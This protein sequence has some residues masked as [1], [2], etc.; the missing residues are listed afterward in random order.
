MRSAGQGKTSPPDY[1]TESELIG[2]MEKHG[3]GTDAS[4]S[5]H[6][7]KVCSA[8]TPREQHPE[9]PP[10]ASTLPMAC[11]SVPTGPLYSVGQ[12]VLAEYFLCGMPLWQVCERY[13]SVQTGRRLVPT[14]LGVTLVRGYQLIDP[15]LC[16]PLVG[17]AHSGLHA[18]SVTTHV[19]HS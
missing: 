4:I 17:F 3:I 15:D 6:I 10:K 9:M 5:V 16:L 7:A 19:F 8:L 2:L 1:L 18:G 14:E 11:L 13:V 12:G